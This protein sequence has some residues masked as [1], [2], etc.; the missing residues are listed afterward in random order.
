M[1]DFNY[2]K[3]KDL[4]RKAILFFIVL[5]FLGLIISYL[6]PG[7]YEWAFYF[8]FFLVIVL[9]V[10]L[11]L[12]PK[13]E[14]NGMK[15]LIITLTTIYFYT[16]FIIYPQ[17]SSTI[18]LLAII[19]GA[20]ILFFQ[21]ML[22]YLSLCLNIIFM[23]VI[24]GYVFF[25]DK[26]DNYPYLYLDLIGNMINFLGSQGLLFLIFYFSHTRMKQLQLYYEQIQQAERLKTTGQLAAAVAHEIRNPITV[27]KGFLQLYKED[28]SIDKQKKEHF[29]LMLDELNVAETVISDF[30][31]IAKPKGNIDSSTVNVKNA[32]LSVTDLIQS[33]ALLH[34]I[35]LKIDVQNEYIISC[36]LMEFKQL[37][38]NLLKNAIEASP[39]DGTI[40]IEVKEKKK[41][42]EI[43][44]I[45]SGCGMTK[46]Q[47]SAIGTPFYTLKSKGTG[48]GLMICFNIV[49]KYNGSIQF[50]SEEGKGTKVSICLPS[51]KAE[52]Q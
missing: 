43:L 19:P 35:S 9:S 30:L 28:D 7:Q 26:G 6:D 18:I 11:F 46:E 27:V 48:L 31:S 34:N 44:V 47:L 38:I 4:Y 16:L 1:R 32:I 8:Q 39:N 42:I 12:Y 3:N 23:T 2:S 51:Q 29:S 45:D 50:Q 20:V 24:F 52:S 15:F 22:F 13:K 10:L 21:P 36:S 5:M 25:I 17:T 49:Q 33:Y 14:T 40:D 37:M 41:F